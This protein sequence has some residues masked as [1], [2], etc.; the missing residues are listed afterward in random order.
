M[1]LLFSCSCS[2]TF[3]FGQIWIISK[4]DLYAEIPLN[5]HFINGDDWKLENCAL[6]V[7]LSWTRPCQMAPFHRNKWSCVAYILNTTTKPRPACSPSSLP[8]N[9]SSSKARAPLL[10]E[11][12]YLHMPIS[13]IM[14]LERWNMARLMP[15]RIM[16]T[17]VFLIDRSAP[18]NKI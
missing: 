18:I 9:E 5:Y 6:V 11:V 17:M 13:A 14:G 15:E 4:W 2:T 1:L 10:T 12:A 8:S 16:N 3:S 7:C